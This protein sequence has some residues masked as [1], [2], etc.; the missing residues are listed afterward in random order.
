MHLIVA[1]FDF[2][3]WLGTFRKLWLIR[4]PPGGE[5]LVRTHVSPVIAVCAVCRRGKQ[6]LVFIVELFGTLSVHARY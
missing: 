3:F 4:W 1:C 6:G 5:A 2:D